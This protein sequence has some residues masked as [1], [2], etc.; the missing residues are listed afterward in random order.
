MDLPPRLLTA[1]LFFIAATVGHAQESTDGGLP[2]DPAKEWIAHLRKCQRGVSGLQ[3]SFVQE[4]LHKLETHSEVM[5]GVVKLRRG[6]RIRVA[7]SEPVRRL[8]VSDGHALWAFD[9]GQKTAV[10]GRAA[11]SLLPRLFGFFLD[12]GERDSFVARHLG[13]DTQPGSGKAAVQLVPRN[14]DPIVA[15]FVLTLENKCPG[16][17]RVLVEDHAGVVTR[18]TLSKIRT[19]LGFGQKVF[20]FKPPPGVKIVQ[21]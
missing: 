4:R 3:A 15:S 19:N 17:S 12:D 1:L 8:I 11:H 14:R 18:V 16:V 2:D 5:K 9:P 20:V 7:Y 6:G 21:P 13:G 10:E